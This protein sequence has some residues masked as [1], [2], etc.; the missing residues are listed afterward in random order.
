MNTLESNIKYIF[1]LYVF[2]V[3]SMSL[4]GQSSQP[5]KDNNEVIYRIYAEGRRIVP[6]KSLC[7]LWNQ[8]AERLFY[9]GV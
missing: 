1:T 9:Y 8:A 7:L 4:K 2:Q 6:Q 5:L 3:F